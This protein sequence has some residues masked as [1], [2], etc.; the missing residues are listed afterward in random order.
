MAQGVSSNPV[1]SRVLALDGL[2][3]LMTILVVV[4]HYFGEI[5]HGF[6]GLMFGWIAVDMFY[7]L[8]GYLIGRLILEKSHHVNFFKVFYL[9]RLCRTLPVYFFC[10]AAILITLSVV[11]RPEWTREGVEFPAW[12]YMTFTQNIWMAA[13]DSVGQ[14]WLAPTWTLALEEQFYLVAPALMLMTPRRWLVHALCGCIALGILSRAFVYQTDYFYGA[15]G[16]TLLPTN[17]DVLTF[18][19]LAAVLMKSTKIDWSKYDMTLRVLPVALLVLTILIKLVTGENSTA[20]Q[21][22]GDFFVSGACAIFIMSLVR[23]VP[24]AIRF[25]SPVLCF[26]GTTSYSVYLTHLPILGVMHGLLLGA[27]PDIA[28]P[29]QIA[30]TFAALPVCVFA[31]WIVTKLVEAPISGY[32]RSFKWSTELKS[33]GGVSTGKP[34]PV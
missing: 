28:T 12:A 23:G 34:V 2:R 1:E 17:A 32:G 6:K 3:G 31:G 25:R 33:S 22:L 26:F 20:F 21:I 16:A 30:V 9:R 8:S 13:T 14:H 29:T 18:G 15:A 27:K 10:V 4:S 7:V 5:A 11:G 24:E 19:I